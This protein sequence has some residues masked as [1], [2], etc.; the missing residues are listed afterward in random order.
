MTFKLRS[1]VAALAVGTLLSTTA[2]CS[3]DDSE[4]TA[5][6]GGEN[7][8]EAT[9]NGVP[10]PC[11]LLTAAQINEITENVYSEGTRDKYTQVEG[12]A[13]CDFEATENFSIVQVLIS[14]AAPDP[15]EQ[16]AT[17]EKNVGRSEDI[18][19]EG[20]TDAYLVTNNG[21]VGMGIDGYFVQVAI[22]GSGEGIDD[23]VRQLAELV[24]AAF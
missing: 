16:R 19:I 10:D 1:F 7:T 8:E 20:A 9:T 15:V 12:Q 2:A 17:T 18:T 11:A 14:S 5:T 22:V 24:A 23:Q 4:T 13:T 21:T 6:G 3:S